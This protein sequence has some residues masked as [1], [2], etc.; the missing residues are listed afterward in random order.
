MSI[1]ARSKLLAMQPFEMVFVLLLAAVVT[2]SAVAGFLFARH[3]INAKSERKVAKAAKKAE[4]RAQQLSHQV[5]PH[6]APK[7]SH[8]QADS[9]SITDLHAG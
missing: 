4:K 2:F 7:Q 9:G 5:E 8:F 1:I 6:D 3:E